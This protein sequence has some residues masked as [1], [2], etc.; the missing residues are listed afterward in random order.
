MYKYYRIPPLLFTQIVPVEQ[1]PTPHVRR[2]EVI[3]GFQQRPLVPSQ[4]TAGAR[5]FYLKDPLPG[6]SPGFQSAAKRRQQ[7]AVGV[8]P[9][10]R[11]A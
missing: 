9:W 11:V 5:E 6:A 7:V 3:P 10:E 4:D 1:L 2:S 8:S